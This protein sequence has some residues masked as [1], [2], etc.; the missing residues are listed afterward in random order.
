MIFQIYSYRSINMF[1]YKTNA[2]VT[3]AP[4]PPQ[5]LNLD[6]SHFHSARQVIRDVTSYPA[7][8]EAVICAI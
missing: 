4:F 7:N 5:P 2:H 6:R 3:L 1:S 8:G